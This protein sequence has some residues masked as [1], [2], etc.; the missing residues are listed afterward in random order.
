MT[1][2]INKKIRVRILGLAGLF[3]V[4][5]VVIGAKA[6]YL[7]VIRGPWLSEKAANQYETSFSTRG[8]RGIIYDREYREMAVSIDATS[9]A[10]YPAH[11][12]WADHNLFFGGT[13]TVCW[14]G[15]TFTG[16]GDPRRGGVFA[17]HD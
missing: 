3:S 1:V 11:R 2:A 13:H 14:D 16:A 5:L 10:A 8:K 17:V 9:I 4:F 7:Q 15:R 12:L 6:V